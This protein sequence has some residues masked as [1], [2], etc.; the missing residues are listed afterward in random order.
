[1]RSPIPD[2][3]PHDPRFFIPNIEFY[4]TNVCNLTCTNCNRFN[5][6]DFKGWQNWADYASI[7]EEW[8]KHIRFQRITIMGGEPLLNPSLCDWVAGINR[9]WGKSVQILTNGTRLNHVP[10][11]Y[12]LLTDWSDPKYPWI[13][14]WIGISLH[15]PNDRE[16][17]FDTIKKFLKGPIDYI[18]RDDPRNENN[19]HTMGGDHAFVDVNGVRICVWEYDDFYTAAVQRT[20]AGRFVLYNND[21]EEAHYHCGFARYKCHHFAKGK[22]YKCGPVALMPEFDEQHNIDLSD[23]DRALLNSYRPLT[24]EEFSTRGREFFDNIDNP[25]P[26]CKFCPTQS[27][28]TMTRLFAV[29]KKK[30]ATSGY[31]E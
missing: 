23:Q 7:Y 4:I 8:G 22:I 26:Q 3:D 30:G 9:I 28:K 17:C 1:M 21:P 14:N 29:S 11:L 20:S 19:A 18:S 6:H 31:D 27:Q 16:K 5:N 25:I 12:E 24:V 15:N 13:K 2:A 10:G